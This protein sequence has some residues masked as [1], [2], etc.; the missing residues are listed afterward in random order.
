[1]D[2]CAKEFA[3]KIGCKYFIKIT[4]EDG[5]C[6]MCAREK[7]RARKMPPTHGEEL[8]GARPPLS[9]QVPEEG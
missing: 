6:I 8:Q 3:E 7:E 9:P 4:D 1:L 5:Y 2:S